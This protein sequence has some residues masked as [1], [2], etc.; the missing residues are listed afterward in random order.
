MRHLR[1]RWLGFFLFTFI[2]L[3]W[4]QAGS[5]LARSRRRHHYRHR[6]RR[7]AARLHS[8]TR[9][10]PYILATSG[11]PSRKTARSGPSPSPTPL[12]TTVDIDHIEGQTLYF[13]APQGVTAPKPLKL[14][15]FEPRYL[16]LLRP[17]AGGQPYYLLS[18]RTC[19][20]CLE[21]TGLFIVQ[22]AGGKPY[23]YVYPGKIFENKGHA[24]AVAS[25]A[26]YGHCLR[27]R[28]D[29]V[30]VI[31]QAEKVD[32][33]H[34]LLTSVLIAEPQTDERAPDG[35]EPSTPV[36]VPDHLHE[37][38]IERHLPRIRNTLSLVKSGSCTEI[39]GRNRVMAS[40]PL[41]VDL[42]RQKLD[43]ED[44][45]DQDDDST[46]ADGPESDKGAAA[47]APAEAATPTN[48]A[49]H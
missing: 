46:S 37:W 31:Y 48:A 11:T 28:T 35:R 40:R 17:A 1:G 49:Q 16:G 38:L 29:D 8:E 44:E 10:I 43:D 9:D 36:K 21:D 13:H 2:S 23:S 33:R 30:L 27:D 7:S 26:F 14:D 39:V 32:R 5:G 24:L 42:H 20:N 18:G 19:E 15:L 3:F 47:A 41:D 34:G 12:D 45:D 6:H 22:A 4:I 25:R